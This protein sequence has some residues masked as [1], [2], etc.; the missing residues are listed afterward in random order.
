MYFAIFSW[1]M[2][3]KQWGWGWTVTALMQMYAPK[4]SNTCKNVALY[5]IIHVNPRQLCNK[6]M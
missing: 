2:I 5:V 1:I 3:I 4:H 6:W